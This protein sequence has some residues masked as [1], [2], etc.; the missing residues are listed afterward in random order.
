M[1]LEEGTTQAVS[2]ACPIDS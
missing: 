2:P 1:K